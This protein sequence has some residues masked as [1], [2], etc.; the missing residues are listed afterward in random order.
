[1]ANIPEDVRTALQNIYDRH[2]GN[3]QSIFQRAQRAG[4]QIAGKPITK[5][6]VQQFLSGFRETQVT[7]RFRRPK[8]FSSIWSRRP[9][10]NIQIDLLVLAAP[11]P[12]LSEKEIAELRR[13]R[14]QRDLTDYASLYGGYRYALVAVDVKTRKVWAKLLKERTASTFN[15][16]LRGWL[17]QWKSRNVHGAPLTINA[18]QE[19]ANNREFKQLARTYKFDIYGSSRNESNKNAVVE[20]LNRTL[21]EDIRRFRKN[22]E[23]RE[24]RMF[25]N[26]PTTFKNIIDNYNDTEHTTTGVTPDSANDGKKES[27]QGEPPQREFAADEGLPP[28]PAKGESAGL[29][30]TP[31]V[32][33]ARAINAKYNFRVGQYVR[34][35]T[36]RNKFLKAS[37]EATYSEEIYEISRHIGQ[38]YFLRELQSN[39]R[40]KQELARPFRGYELLAVPERTVQQHLRN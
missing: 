40:L 21:R 35:V 23:L 4:I 10:A 28:L 8:K 38:S 17:R 18:D 20:R 31:K 39:G 3:L 26:F 36:D 19:F 11:K 12:E 22:D 5:G 37:N 33:P 7:R 16:V 13:K 24:R 32:I 14:S 2:P 1:M 30:Y 9:M 34:R 29:K 27:L 25:G 6:R 15:N